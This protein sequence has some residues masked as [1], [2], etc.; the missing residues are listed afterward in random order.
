MLDWFIFDPLFSIS[1]TVIIL[2]LY[3]AARLEGRRKR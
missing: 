3:G 1:A 2:V